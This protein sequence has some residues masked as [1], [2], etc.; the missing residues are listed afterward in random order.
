MNADSREQA[1]LASIR[2]IM[3]AAEQKLLRL[4]ETGETWADVVASAR[5]AWDSDPDLRQW[6]IDRGV[7]PD[8]FNDA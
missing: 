3:D 2:R 4:D 8:Q 1:V 6:L 7:D 5:E